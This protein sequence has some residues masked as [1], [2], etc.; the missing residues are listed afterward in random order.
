MW[1]NHTIS[2]QAMHLLK[3]LDRFF[4]RG[5]VIGHIIQDGCGIQ[6]HQS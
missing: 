2:L 4:K 5:V 3:L 6:I 1:A